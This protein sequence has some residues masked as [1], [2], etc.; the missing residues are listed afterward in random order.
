MVQD[1][2]T[3]I[4]VGKRDAW[5]NAAD[6]PSTHA[7]DTVTLNDQKSEDCSALTKGTAC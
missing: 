1:Y 4:V 3:A 5:Q 2:S 7:L 6:K